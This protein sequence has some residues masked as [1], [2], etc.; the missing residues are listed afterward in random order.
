MTYEET[1]FLIYTMVDQLNND[2]SFITATGELIE[3]RVVYVQVNDKGLL[4]TVATVEFEPL[5]CQWM[6]SHEM[7]KEVEKLYWEAKYESN[8]VAYA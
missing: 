1:Q 8:K 4:I 5:Y 6:M 2:R 3:G 7:A